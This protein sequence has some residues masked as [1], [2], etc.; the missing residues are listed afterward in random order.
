MAH[1]GLRPAR[2]QVESPFGVGVVRIGTGEMLP[3]S[4]SP[5]WHHQYVAIA[6]QL[7]GAQFAARGQRENDDG[8]VARRSVQRPTGFLLDG[9]LRE[10]SFR[11]L[12][13]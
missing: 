4:R 8:D 11:R 6:M 13:H 5:L 7:A 9:R 10:G 12:N 2:D 1:L 3:P